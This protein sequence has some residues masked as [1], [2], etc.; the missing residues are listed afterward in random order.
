MYLRVVSGQLKPGTW[1][2]FERAYRDAIEKGGMIN[3]LC[4][5]WLTRDLENPDAG[6]TISLWATE[7]DLRAYEASDTLR[8]RIQPLLTPFF[9]GQYRIARSV[10]R[11]AEGDPAPQEWVGSDN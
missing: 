9:T 5:R 4:G 7:A 1:D 3:G 8:N 2:A 6:T 10:V 11:R